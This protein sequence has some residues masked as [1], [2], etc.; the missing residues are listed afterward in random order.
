MRNLESI[1]TNNSILKS[2]TDLPAFAGAMIN[3]FK[4]VN[5]IVDIPSITFN[6]TPRIGITFNR[7]IINKETSVYSV[8]YK[9]NVSN[10]LDF[11]DLLYHFIPGFKILEKASEPGKI[12]FKIE[13]DRNENDMLIIRESLLSLR[14]ALIK[15]KHNRK[16]K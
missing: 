10:P 14:E 16:E 5:N 4:S 6:I 1:I 2:I 13:F 12:K 11:I 8:I 15:C 9:S 7:L 3:L